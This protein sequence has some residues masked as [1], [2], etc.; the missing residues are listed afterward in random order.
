MHVIKHRAK[1][2]GERGRRLEVWI[3]MDVIENMRE[4]AKRKNLPMWAA[5]EDVLQ[6]NVSGH[7]SAVN[8]PHNQ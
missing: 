4:V 3:G 7:A 2:R 5:V 1:L 6:A 8:A